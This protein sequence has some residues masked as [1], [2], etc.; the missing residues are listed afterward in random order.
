M[1][2][3]I[4]GTSGFEYPYFPAFNNDSFWL[5]ANRLMRML[6]GIME[7]TT[8]LFYLIP[9]YQVIRVLKEGHEERYRDFIFPSNGA[10]KWIRNIVIF[11]LV[12]A[13]LL[14]AAYHCYRLQ[15]EKIDYDDF[16]FAIYLS[17]IVYS[18]VFPTILVFYIFRYA[19][20]RWVDP[21]FKR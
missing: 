20:K 16:G 11:V 21:E 4:G 2:I 6:W 1:F 13:Y 15:A 14:G 8:I 3:V 10:L 7:I 5:P 9:F 19:G 18:I 17:M 12:A